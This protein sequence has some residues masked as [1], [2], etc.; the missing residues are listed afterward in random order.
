[1][2]TPA[3]LRGA[4]PRARAYKLYDAGGLFLHV[5]A[6]P[7]GRRTWRMRCRIGAAEQLLTFGAFP[8]LSLAQAR[9][10]A[11]DAAEQ[12]RAGGD[13]RR[14]SAPATFAAVARAWHA[15]QLETWSPGHAAEVLAS[16]KR[17]VFPAIGEE[18][19]GAIDTVTIARVLRSVER[20]GARETA[21]RLG[22]R[23]SA[24][25][26]A[27]VYEGTIVSNPAA[28]IGGALKPIALRD[29]H[30]AVITVADA[31]DALARLDGAGGAEVTR[32]AARFL[33]LTA[34][35]WGA[36]RAMTWSEIGNNRQLALGDPAGINAWTIPAAHMKLSVARKADSAHDHVV[37]LSAAAREVLEQVRTLDRGGELVFA[38]AGGAPIGADAVRA[39]HERAGL[40]G[41]HAPHGWRASFS[42][43]L[44]ERRPRDRAAIDLALA[45]APK[46]KVEAAYNRAEL[47]PLRRELLEEWA[48][49]LTLAPGLLETRYG[50]EVLHVAAHAPRRLA[51]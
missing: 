1:M 32:L 34:V 43:I 6:L 41:R 16:L 46:D 11:A 7:S 51:A 22:Q 47:L 36:V 8:D 24:I 5:A 27:A 21:A 26:A 28:E 12:I 38:G 31:R 44:N 39:L 17:H 50:S 49:L 45:H 23:I 42:T 35:R 25:F 18:P 40:A 2:L 4:T 48:D 13:P 10:R 37:P 14:R 3:A 19:I 9:A 15:A 29:R 33:A 20:A 30:A